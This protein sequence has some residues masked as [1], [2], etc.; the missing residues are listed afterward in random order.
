LALSFVRDLWLA[1]ACSALAGFGLILFFATGQSVIQLRTA[2][3]NRGQIMGI[4]AMTM[5]GGV[6]LGGLLFGP[7]ADQWGVP[8][9]IRIEGLGCAGAAL[10]LFVVLWFLRRS[11]RL[12]PAVPGESAA[13]PT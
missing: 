5:N 10:Y 3:H 7:L 12:K 13:S 6:P 9:A 11:D 2:E 8:L 4:W 1:I